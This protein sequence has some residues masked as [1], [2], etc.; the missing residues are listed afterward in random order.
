MTIEREAI[1]KSEE[2]LIVIGMIVSKEVLAELEPIYQEHFFVS[3]YARIVSRW[4]I[5][6]WREYKE[7]PYQHIQDIYESNLRN[8]SLDSDVADL[9]GKF[10][11][12][13]SEQYEREKFNSEFVLD[14]A[15]AFF[16]KRSLIALTEDI[17]TA[18]I[19][20]G[21]ER[22]ESLLH[23]FKPVEREKSKGIDLFSKETILKAFSE[24]TSQ[25]LFR[26]PG[27]LGKELGPFERDSLIG[28]MGP[29][30]RGKTF[31]LMEFAMRA[32]RAR[33]NVAFFQVG[34]LS[35][36]QQVRRFHVYLS[37]RNYKKRYCGKIL[38]P[39]LD[40]E[41]NQRNSCSR[42]ER[43][44]RTG[45]IREDESILS[46]DEAVNYKACTACLGNERTGFLYK[47]AVWYEERFIEPLTWKDAYK[48]AKEFVEIS[49]GK[50]FKLSVHPAA[51]ISVRGITNILDS[52]EKHE[53]FIVDVVVIDYADILAPEDPRK[54][55]RHQQNE[56]WMAL[57]RLSQEK[58]CCVITATQADAKSYDKRS[59]ALSNFSEDKRKYAHVT[60]MLSLNQTHEEKA[61]GIMRI[62]KMIA[63]E[64]EFDIL[65][66]IT[67]LQCLKIG[68]PYLGSY[69]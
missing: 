49:K 52:W 42:P 3:P 37:Q 39:I 60:M 13:I 67:V 56:T 44:S 53:D 40:C 38:I 68:R 61:R 62:S 18:L 54:E 31:W 66:E 48:V 46:F 43:T 21:V 28:I 2:R 22:A 6:Y 51:S 12:S 65:R 17:R 45:V 63:R 33:C 58:H 16:K 1:H 19:Q 23:K 64:D 55:F 26:M 41:L 32:F 10:L 59:I 35:E 69:I 29:E 30:K 20:Q 7:A 4:C 9:I 47:G 11:S 5:N 14:L 15:E 34:D 27:V 24:D 25:I 8:G 50:R 36:A 57:R